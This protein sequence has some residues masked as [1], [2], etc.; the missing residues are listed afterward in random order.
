[1]HEATHQPEYGR[2]QDGHHQPGGHTPPV[3]QQLHQL[4]REGHEHPAEVERVDHKREGRQ[5]RTT[6]EAAGN[7]GQDIA[8]IPG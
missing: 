7:S 1:M 3:G 5:D 6:H 2:R 4:R 8:M